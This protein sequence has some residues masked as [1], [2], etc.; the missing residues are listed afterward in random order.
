ME[1]NILSMEGSKMAEM[2]LENLLGPQHHSDV[3]PMLY[4]L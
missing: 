1:S 4:L 3:D 2:E